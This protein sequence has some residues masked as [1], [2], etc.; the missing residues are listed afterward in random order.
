MRKKVILFNWFPVTHVGGVEVYLNE[1]LREMRDHAYYICA[2]SD[3]KEKDITWL[4]LRSLNRTEVPSKE[5]VRLD[6]E[7]IS[8][9]YNDVGIVHFHNPHVFNPIGMEVVISE[10]QKI[11]LNSKI[12]ISIHNLPK[13]PEFSMPLIRKY[14][15]NLV[16]CS[17]FLSGEV[18][19]MY[20]IKT[21]IPILPYLFPIPSEEVKHTITT[22]GI[23]RILQPT[24]FCNWKGSHISLSAVVR[25][26]EEGNF[27]LVFTHAGT[28]RN[29]YESRWDG[30]WDQKLKKKVDN[31]V[32]KGNIKFI[33]Y[34]PQ[35]TYNYYMDHDIIVHPT[36]G[37]E[38]QG[39]PNPIAAL[40]AVLMNIPIIVTKSGNLPMI[41]KKAAMHRIIPT[42]D[43]NA[44]INAI[45][46]L[47][48]VVKG[49]E[50]GIYKVNKSMM[51]ELNNA[52]RIHKDFYE[53]VYTQKIISV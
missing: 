45:K 24:R 11:C 42:E 40:Q 7:S 33:K 12:V 10:L 14:R 37:R 44:L 30:R 1:L 23:L 25:L 53:D 50:E 43:V 20:G 31:F 27:P 34:L 52:L 8:I 17:E 32:K 2:N 47:S 41:A 46:E 13:D 35:E 18:Q 3:H 38:S 26:L 9:D 36:V 15:N 4:E 51:T 49:N 6:L 21:K 48:R 39:D 5:D 28:D 22:D 19:S 16:T 29:H